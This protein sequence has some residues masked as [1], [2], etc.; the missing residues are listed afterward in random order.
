MELPGLAGGVTSFTEPFCTAGPT[1]SGAIDIFLE[2]VSHET[3]NYP[4]LWAAISALLIQ[5][6][7]LIL[8]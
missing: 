5:Q 8:N 7:Q 3:C 6:G 4:Y 2:S 1:L